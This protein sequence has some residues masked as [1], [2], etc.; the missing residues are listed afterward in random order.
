MRSLFAN[1]QRLSVKKQNRSASLQ[2]SS[3]NQQRDLVNKRIPFAEKQR[4]LANKQNGQKSGKIGFIEHFLGKIAVRA[5][6]AV[7]TRAVE[8]SGRLTRASTAAREARALPARNVLPTCSRQIIARPDAPLDSITRYG[9]PARRRI[10]N[11]RGG[12]LGAVDEGVNR[13]T[14]LAKARALPCRLQV[15]STF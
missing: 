1:P 3:A 14:V 2:S 6:I 5:S 9:I 13:R 10:R 8:R 7:G 15:G 11:S 12:S 4:G